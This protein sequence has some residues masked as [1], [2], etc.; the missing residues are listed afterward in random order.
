MP[1]CPDGP[2]APGRDEPLGPGD[3]SPAR[4]RPLTDDLAD[5]RRCVLGVFYVNRDDPSFFVEKRFGLGYTIN[6]GNPLAVVFLVLFLAA[7]AAITEIG[8]LTSGS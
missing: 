7:I 6:F 5:N 4:T 8:I 1:W 3:R 2:G